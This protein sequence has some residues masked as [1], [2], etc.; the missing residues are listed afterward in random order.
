MLFYV[1]YCKY[2][3]NVKLSTKVILNRNTVLSFGNVVHAKS[4]IA[5]TSIGT[6]TY[7]GTDC[8]LCNCKIGKYCSIS[9]NI[10]IVNSTHPTK[11]FVSTHPA[12][13][14]LLKQSGFTFTSKQRF[15][16]H[17]YVDKE[18]KI[19]V[20][21]GNDVWIGSKVTII[22]GI[23]IGDGAIIA[24]GAIVTENVEPYSIVA[25]VPAR[26]IRY[27]FTQEQIEFIRN[28]KWWDKPPEWLRDNV[29]SFENVEY[30]K[31]NILSQIR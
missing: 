20:I 28:T 5:N 10:V 19:S 9:N 30:F 1:P 27:R 24:T 11:Q 17:L 23:E 2:R 8:S 26:H 31:R 6:G 13:F 12:F 22:G 16:E 21:I 15:C 3:K 29:D 25:G 4:A 7:V 14:S 18:N